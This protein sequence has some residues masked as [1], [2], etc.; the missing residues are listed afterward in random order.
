MCAIS[1]IE[2]YL[3]GQKRKENKIK[4]GGV[5]RRGRRYTEQAAKLLKFIIL[6]IS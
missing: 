2:V 4:S 6:S 3:F 1:D 5:M